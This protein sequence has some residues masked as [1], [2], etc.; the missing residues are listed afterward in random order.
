MIQIPGIQHCPAWLLQCETLFFYRGGAISPDPIT[1]L[2]PALIGYPC[3]AVH[4]PSRRDYC[5]I[6]VP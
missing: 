5:Y 3:I 1:Q 4:K 2:V 6:L